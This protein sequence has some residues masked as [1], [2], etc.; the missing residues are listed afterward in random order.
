MIA[1]DVMGF[2]LL[3]TGFCACA[4]HWGRARMGDPDPGR[5]SLAA[6]GAWRFAPAGVIVG[7]CVAIAAAFARC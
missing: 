6:R 1:S 2:G 5:D 3:L 4:W 7:I